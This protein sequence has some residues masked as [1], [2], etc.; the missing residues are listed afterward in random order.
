MSLALLGAAMLAGVFWGTA[1]I[2][3]S[4]RWAILTGDPEAP[5]SLSLIVW[6]WRMP[7]VLAVA[8]I[9]AGLSL[10]GALMQTALRNPLAD[11]YLMGLSSGASAAAVAMI[12]WAP[13]WIAD[14]LGV[15][16]A[17]FLGA[18]AAFGI[19]L[20]LAF[21]PGRMLS[22]LVVILAGVAV[23][24]MFQSLTAFFLYIG[25][26]QAT[27]AAL[28]WLMGT[29][30]GTDWSDLPVLAL[31]TTTVAGAAFWRAGDLDTLLLGD[32][33]AAALGMRVGLLR[34]LI[35]VGTALLTGLSVAVAGIVGFVGLIVPH[36]ARL[37]IGARHRRLLP[38]AMV[39]GAIVLVCVDLLCRV[40]LAPEE[41]PLGVLLALF[42][43]PP[44]IFILRRVRDVA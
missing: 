34:L 14:V 27:R 12:I 23:S 16:L 40:L 5:R 26:P 1:Q 22:P 33:R 11:P 39:L 4:D 15:P 43:A 36:M 41:L 8:L 2:G 18:S 37:L 21:R 44:F 28:G 20:G 10:A 6:Q 31:A 19:T 9:G 38:L 32:E 24:L 13:A 29:A 7:R 35:F 42:A 25:D 17:A 30:A 3:W